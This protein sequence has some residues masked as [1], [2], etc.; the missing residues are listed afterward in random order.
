[1]PFIHVYYGWF[2]QHLLNINSQ[3]WILL[4]SSSIDKMKY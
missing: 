1:M 4:M 3:S 2:H